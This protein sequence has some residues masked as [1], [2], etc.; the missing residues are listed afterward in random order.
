MSKKKQGASQV[1][2]ST[3][4]FARF[5]EG[6]E[7]K[8]D[9]RVEGRRSAAY[10]KA[11]AKKPVQTL[12]FPS[13]SDELQLCPYYLS[14]AD[15]PKVAGASG[16]RVTLKSAQATAAAI[17]QMQPAAERDNV[18]ALLEAMF[19]NHPYR[20]SPEFVGDRLCDAVLPGLQCEPH[21]SRVQAT[22]TCLVRAE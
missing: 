22:A 17:Q 3:P 6:Q 9:A 21:Q 4:F 12:K 2:A 8:S 1:E 7:E 16:G 14:A 20:R 19:P 15:V 5:L 10:K 13:D 11:V 18:G